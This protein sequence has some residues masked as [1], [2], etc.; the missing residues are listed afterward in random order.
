[1]LAESMRQI[2]WKAHWKSTAKCVWLGCNNARTGDLL[3]L[4]HK[5]NADGRK[6]GVG[7][8]PW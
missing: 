2:H 6:I 1:M 7:V 5:T 3:C 8:Q 4:Y